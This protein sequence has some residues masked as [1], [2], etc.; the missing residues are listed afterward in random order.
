MQTVQ[1]FF[2]K[3]ITHF[4]KQGHPAGQYE[5]LFPV[6]P[7]IWQCK[8][9]MSNGDRCAV[10]THIPDDIYDA[11]MDEGY[12]VRALIEKFPQVRPFLCPNTELMVAL[13]HAHDNREHWINPSLMVN[14]LR[15]IARIFTLNTE[16]LDSLDFSNICQ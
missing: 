14:S 13:Q 8:Y 10:G 11:V 7:S 12:G 1:E 4:V 3:T 15:D 9:R 2:D 6:E 5:K 16:V